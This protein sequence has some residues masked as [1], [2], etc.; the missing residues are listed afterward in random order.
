[1]ALAHIFNEGELK[2][3][4][5]KDCQRSITINIIL[6]AELRTA[7]FFTVVEFH[8]SN[9]CSQDYS[10]VGLFFMVLVYA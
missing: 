3:N 9:S 10:S 8:A 6:D 1:M 7:L 4:V 2:A 5:N